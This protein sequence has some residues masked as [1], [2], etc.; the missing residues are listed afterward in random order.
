MSHWELL[1]RTQSRDKETNVR[2]S[3][4]AP[5]EPRSTAEGGAIVDLGIRVGV[6]LLRSQ[7]YSHAAVPDEFPLSPLNT[8]GKL[9]ASQ[10][11]RI[12]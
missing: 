4:R 5:E 10:A 7:L 2:R 9:K 12:E 1:P 11:S 3:A 6:S 8:E